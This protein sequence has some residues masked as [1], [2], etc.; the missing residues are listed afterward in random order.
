MTPKISVI[1][2]AFNAEEHIAETIDSV[3]NQSIG[4]ENLEII[5]VDHKSSDNTTKILKEYDKNFSNITAILLSKNLTG[6]PSYPRNLGMKHACGEYIMFMDA[7]DMYERD[8]CEKLYNLINK[9]DAD[10]ISC[11]FKILE[12]NN[13]KRVNYNFLE[14]DG[15][16]LLFNSIFERPEIVYASANMSIWNKI[17]RK[18]FLEDENITYHKYAMEDTI[19]MVDC[20]MA[21]NRFIILNNYAGYIYRSQRDPGASFSHTP[22]KERLTVAAKCV[23]YGYYKA[24]NALVDYTPHLNE[25][26]VNI[27]VVFLDNE[28]SNKEQKEILE[29]MKPMYKQYK[30][31]NRFVNVSLVLNIFINI[32]MIIFKSNMNVALLIQKIYKTLHLKKVVD[33]II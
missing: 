18:K 12:R 19:F 8:M 13:I 7:D 3:I 28:L 22:S 32:F 4:F 6:N 15:D 21:S 31:N 33:K 27:T 1:V 14:K 9:T 11:R 30:W 23:V 2:P 20:Y 24:K 29:I 5:I 17:F 16:C 25:I 10:F 26:L